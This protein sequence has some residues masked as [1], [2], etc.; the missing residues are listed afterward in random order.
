VCCF[1]YHAARS[2]IFSLAGYILT[3]L[4]CQVTFSVYYLYLAQL[5]ARPSP[6]AV[7]DFDEL[8]VAFTRMLK[9]GLA[10]WPE[11]GGDIETLITKRPGSPAE[12]IQHLEQHDQRAI[13]FRNSIRTWFCKAPWSSIKLLELR[14]W[15][16]WAMFHAD[17]P[18][19]EE[20]SNSHK[21]ILDEGM[22]QL[23]RRLG[24]KVDEGTDP[25]IMPMR[26][27]L[28]R[29]GIQGRPLCFYLLIYSTSLIL[30]KLY[31]AW[32]G[33]QCSHFDGIEYVFPGLQ[34][35]SCH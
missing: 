9:A 30:R 28:D 20:M 31:Q 22:A 33:V 7:R 2:S 4:C 3:Q 35:I 11:N 34:N 19:P 8:H 25:L 32:W 1:L 23:Q 16:Y 14:K 15:L 21:A 10:D 17:L 5:V 12:T 29:T 27:S 26:L 6:I 13:D 24:C 18:K